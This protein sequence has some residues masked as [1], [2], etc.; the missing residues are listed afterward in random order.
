MTETKTVDVVVVDDANYETTFKINNPKNNITL[1]EIREVFAPM[2]A[3]GYLKSRY[4]NG[5]ASVARANITTI[6][7]TTVA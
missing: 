5:V 7:K 6:S 4:G 2:I 1:Q 3:N